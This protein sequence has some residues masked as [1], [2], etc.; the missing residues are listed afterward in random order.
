MTTA[1]S[2]RRDSDA[3]HVRELLKGRIVNGWITLARIALK[4]VKD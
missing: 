4:A 3:E 2:R 1:V